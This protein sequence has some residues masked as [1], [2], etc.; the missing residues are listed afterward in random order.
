MSSSRSH[1]PMKVLN[2]T[3]IKT[4]LRPQIHSY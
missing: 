2:K 3:Q 1:K 4:K